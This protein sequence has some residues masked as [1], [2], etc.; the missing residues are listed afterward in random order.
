MMMMMDVTLEHWFILL[1]SPTTF[2]FTTVF[3]L[4]H[5]ILLLIPVIWEHPF[6][7]GESRMLKYAAD[8]LD[9]SILL[10][11]MLKLILVVEVIGPCCLW[12]HRFRFGAPV[13]TA[14]QLPLWRCS[15][16]S[17]WKL[18]SLSLW[19]LCF[20][21]SLSRHDENISSVMAEKDETGHLHQI[22][23]D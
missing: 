7:S 22:M 3:A 16:S 15:R 12:L 2:R 1:C 17:S 23:I 6:T 8:V 14:C 11:T 13:R 10:G 5:L 21:V 18:R 4:I 9:N 19:L 20:T